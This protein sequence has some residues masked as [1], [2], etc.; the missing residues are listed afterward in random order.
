[1]L[2]STKKRSPPN[3]KTGAHGTG[4]GGLGV[5][6]LT[7]RGG[8]QRPGLRVCVTGFRDT[9]PPHADSALRLGEGTHVL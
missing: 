5:G 6:R 4:A 1:M 7:S 8:V 3:Y 2:H 9:R